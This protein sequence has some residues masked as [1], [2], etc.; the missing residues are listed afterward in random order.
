MMILKQDINLYQKEAEFAPLLSATR[1]IQ[2]WGLLLLVLLLLAIEQ[3]WVAKNKLENIEALKIQQKAIDTQLVELSNKAKIKG[4]THQVINDLNDMR[5][6]VAMV[7]KAIASLKE[8]ESK[9]YY[10]L[11][12]YLEGFATRHVNGVFISHFYMEKTGKKMIFEGMALEPRLVP[13]MM[14]AW[15]GA[16]PMAGKS[17][18]KFKVQ[19]I[20]TNGAPVQFNLQAE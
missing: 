16:P 9:S 6:K 3:K 15:E 7:E 8:E 4:N 2:I 10:P 12:A 18:Q 13:L 14:Q 5:E 20:K 17:F 1:L 11:S 19:R